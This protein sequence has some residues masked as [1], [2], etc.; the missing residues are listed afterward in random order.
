M[1]FT[2]AVCR[3]RTVTQAAICR[4]LRH[5][6]LTSEGGPRMNRALLVFACLSIGQ[7][8]T[9]PMPTGRVMAV[10]TP[11]RGIPRSRRSIAA[12]SA[13]SRWRGN[14]TPARKATRRPSPS[15]WA[16]RCTATRLRTRP[17]RWMPPP[18]NNCGCSIPASRA[19]ART[20]VSC[21]GRTARM[22]ACSRPSTTSSMRWMP[23]RASPSKVS[24]RTA[25]STCAKT[26]A[27]IRRRNRCAS[28]R[29]ASSTA[30]S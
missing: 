15:S 10:T 1:G 9:P 21:T 6:I 4:R 22:R 17:S 13:A 29:P 11:R 26:S 18:A 2:A 23:S 5:S 16:A 24:A 8:A 12:T 14:T 27:A 28:L 20:A 7:H 3:P 19:W 25:A 30:I